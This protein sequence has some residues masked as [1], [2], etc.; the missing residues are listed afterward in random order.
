MNNVKM[1]MNDIII[2]LQVELGFLMVGHTH[3][4][5]D[6]LFGNIGKWLKKNNALT[7]PGKKF[8]KIFCHLLDHTL[9]TDLLSG[10][11][12]A[13]KMI[14]EAVCLQKMVDVKS[15]LLPN[16]E[17]LH[18]HSNPHIFRFY[19]NTQGHA[20]MK[21]KRWSSDN[22]EPSGNLPGLKLLKVNLVYRVL[23]NEYIMSIALHVVPSGIHMRIFNSTFQIK[24]LIL[25][26]TF[27]YHIFTLGRCD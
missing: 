14:K 11:K 18:N 10:C 23:V 17:E 24:L 12:E 21:Y 26:N 27:V 5:I 15:W 7:V 13:D 25:H 2:G 22:W 4:D 16:T 8:L 3:E 6:A 9:Y 1:N 19:R 20:E